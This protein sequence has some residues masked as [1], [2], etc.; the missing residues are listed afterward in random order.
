MIVPVRHLRILASL[1]A[2][3]FA[4]S[5][6]QRSENS[7]GSAKRRSRSK[8]NSLVEAAAAG[9]LKFVKREI[10]R[11]LK[12]KDVNCLPQFEPAFYEATRCGQA[13]VAMEFLSEEAFEPM[14]KAGE[15]GHEHFSQALYEATRQGLSDVVEK[16]LERTRALAGKSFLNDWQGG[17]LLRIAAFAGHADIV[18]TLL[19]H[20]AEVDATAGRGD[21]TALH[22]AVL[23]GHEPVVEALLAKGANPNAFWG[24]RRAPL[25]LAAM[26]G[27]LSIVKRLLESGADPF[28]VGDAYTALE[29]AALAGQDEVVKLLCEFQKPTPADLSAVQLDKRSWRPANFAAIAGDLPMLKNILRKFPANRDVLRYADQSLYFAA[30]AGRREVV[31]Y[32]LDY[33]VDVNQRAAGGGI[34]NAL[35]AAARAGR[36]DMIDLLLDRG[37]DINSGRPGGGEGT[38]FAEALWG[39]GDEE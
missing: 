12:E 10:G 34:G 35:R 31:E 16:I 4:C 19:S 18:Q 15:S 14:L 37:A 29:T 21:A 27:H 28:L 33:G 39:G 23:L 9:D 25:H 20:G 26:E 38:P 5:C 24:P 3:M 36:T 7:A 2:L 13:K 17:E 8:S 11:A 30:A 1:I 22:I 32:L 6:G